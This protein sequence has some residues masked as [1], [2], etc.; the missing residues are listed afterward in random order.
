MAH[1]VVDERRKNLGTIM[2]AKL[3]YHGWAL[4]FG[5]Q[6][7]RVGRVRAAAACTVSATVL[8]KTKPSRK[9]W[10]AAAQGHRFPVPVS[11]THLT[12]PTICS[13]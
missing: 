2:G 8:L 4:G 13:V 10:I 5:L 6:L 12:L 9:V 7:G 1:E 3:S 11:Y